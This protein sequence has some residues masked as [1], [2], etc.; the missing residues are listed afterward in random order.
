MGVNKADLN[1][2][3]QKIALEYAKLNDKQRENK[4][5]GIDPAP[6]ARKVGNKTIASGYMIP[7]DFAPV[8]SGGGKIV[9]FGKLDG[10]PYVIEQQIVKQFNDK[11]QEVNVVV[12]NERLAKDSDLSLLRKQTDGL[13]DFYFKALPSS[14][15][16]QTPS[17]NAVS[18]QQGFSL[19]E[20]Y[21][22]KGL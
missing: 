11:G 10:K 13:S 21:N 14:Q 5:S 3:R 15:V 1:M 7:I 8:Q 17:Q 2:Q 9:K 6:Y 4:Y 19:E 20:Y 16:K 18:S 12:E 22:E